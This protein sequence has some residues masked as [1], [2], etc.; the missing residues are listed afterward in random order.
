MPERKSAVERINA[1]KLMHHDID[2]YWIP[3]T[4]LPT[5]IG[6]RVALKGSLMEL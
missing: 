6:S 3:K 1:L 5:W 4:R 2:S